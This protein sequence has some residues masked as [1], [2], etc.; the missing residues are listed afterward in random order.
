MIYS[1]AEDSV[2]TKIIK[3]EIPSYKIYEDTETC[4]I[5]PLNPVAKGHVVVFPKRQVDEFFNLTE[6][7]YAALMNVVKK[8]AEHMKVVLKTKRV[9]L[10]IIGLDV[11]HAHVHVI[12]FDDL[13]EYNSDEDMKTIASDE[14]RQE[15]ANKLRMGGV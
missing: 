11:A 9:G 2:F 8:V 4:A 3:G 14:Y 7:D 12:A 15:L 10:K 1:M 13:S 5:I 6:E